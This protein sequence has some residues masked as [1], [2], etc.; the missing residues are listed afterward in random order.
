[1]KRLTAL[2]AVLVLSACGGGGGD[3]ATTSASVEGFW[4]GTTSTGTAVSLAVLENGETWG[5]YAS[6]GYLAGALNGNTTTSGSGVSISGTEFNF[7]TQTSNSGSYSGNVTAK[8]T[9]SIS[10]P[11][12]TKFTGTYDPSYDQPAT[13]ASVA[14]TYAG[15]A[16]TAEVA[17]QPST[18]VI[19]VNGNVSSSYVS[20]TLSCATTGTA[21]PRA[22]GKNVFNIQLT[23]TGNYCAL[24]SGTVVN[25]VATY[26]SVSRQLIAISLNGSKSDGLV[27][28][29]SR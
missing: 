9:I 1:M 11:D 25:G 20:G 13:L 21:T 14:G 12:G 4:N 6:S 16:V 26:D 22:S 24:G 2:A 17:A 28:V 7:L 15:Y 10:A 18:V 29:G 19:D 3:D 27:F 23:F 5:L 8:E